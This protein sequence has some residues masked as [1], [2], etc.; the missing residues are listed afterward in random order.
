M[1]GIK[2]TQKATSGEQMLNILSDNPCLKTEFHSSCSNLPKTTL[3]FAKLTFYPNLPIFYTDISAI[4]VTSRN[5]ENS[6]GKHDAIA[7]HC[8]TP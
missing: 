6:I 4:S 5:S 8:L 7:M 3:D 1:E 2:L